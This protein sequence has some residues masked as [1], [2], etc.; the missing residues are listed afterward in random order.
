MISVFAQYYLE[1][2]DWF[3][4]GISSANRTAAFIACAIAASWIFAGIFK[5]SGFWISLAASAALFYCLLLTQS[6]GALIALAAATASFFFFARVEYGR[7]RILSLCAAG[8]LACAAFF[9]SAASAR[10]SNMLALKSSSANCR[11]DIYLSGIKMLTDAPFGVEVE[12]SPVEIYMRWYQN[13]EDGE[14]YLSMLNSHLEFMCRYGF[15]AA[16]AYIFSWCFILAAVFPHNKSAV[17][18]AAFSTWICYGICASFSNIMNYWVL[19]IIPLIM[20]CV[21]LFENRGAIFKRRRVLACL[22]SSFA[23]LAS[24]YFVSLLLPR[25]CPLHFSKNGNVCCGDKNC[26]KYLVY[27]PSEQ[28]LGVHYGGEL[29]R[30]CAENNAGAIVGVPDDAHAF[31]KTIF[32]GDADFSSLPNE[33]FGKIAMLNPKASDVFADATGGI[34]V[35]LGSFTDW[36]NR[37]EWES[38]AKRSG[39]IKIKI[40]E[41]VSEF[42]PNWT[43]FF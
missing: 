12:K 13:P 21:G 32:C 27:A 26:V 5:K 11:A 1:R 6:R 18:A 34:C 43:R 36:R 40:L 8:L 10:M 35:Y 22:C 39:K 15:F 17:S 2:L 37:R 30:F 9:N 16:A 23:V 31:E 29:L 33:K 42:V 38:I 25:Q 24:V 7:L 20:L 28:I 4:Y 41:G 19:W 14:R 3:G